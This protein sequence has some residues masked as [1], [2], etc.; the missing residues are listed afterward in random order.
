MINKFFATFWCNF[1][2][3]LGSMRKD[4]IR[5]FYKEFKSFITPVRDLSEIIYMHENKETFR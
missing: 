1:Y 4:R 3:F 2:G 5:T